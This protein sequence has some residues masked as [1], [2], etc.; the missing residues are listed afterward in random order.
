MF[1]WVLICNNLIFW[2]GRE[3]L[4]H[5]L[6]VINMHIQ[7]VCHCV[8]RMNRFLYY[9]F[10]RI[11]CVR[12]PTQ[13]QIKGASKRCRVRAAGTFACGRKQILA[14]TSRSHRVVHTCVCACVGVYVCV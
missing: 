8:S 2:F 11:A 5:L 13:I 6:F 3:K 12:I 10:D 7:Q 1:C 9:N 4:T 14:C